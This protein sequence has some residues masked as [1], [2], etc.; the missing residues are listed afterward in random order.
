MNACSCG[1]LT[2][3]ASTTSPLTG[4]YTSL[5]AFT[6]STAAT[7]SLGRAMARAGHATVA[8]HAPTTRAHLAAITLPGLG[9]STYTISPSWFWAKSEMPTVPMPFSTWQ[10]AMR[11]MFRSGR[12]CA[13]AN[14]AG[15]Y[16][17]VLVRLGEIHN[18]PQRD[19]RGEAEPARCGGET[20]RHNTKHGRFSQ[21]EE[22]AHRSQ[23]KCARDQ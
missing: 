19:A 14:A 4:E 12:H 5:A 16:P 10:P 22:T 9:G 8:A 2:V 17:D 18:I 11:V 21:T 3:F 15:T 23:Q 1:V 20:A 6:D 13:R 7:G